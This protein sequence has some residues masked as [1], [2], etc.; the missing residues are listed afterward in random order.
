MPN[1][2]NAF[3]SKYGILILIAIVLSVVFAMFF[4]KPER[5]IPEKCMIEGFECKGIRMSYENSNIRFELHNS[6]SKGLM[7]KSIQLYGED[8]LSCNKLFDNG[9]GPFVSGVHIAPDGSAE[10]QVECEKISSKLVNSGNIVLSARI[11]WYAEDSSEALSNTTNG[12]LIA[13]VGP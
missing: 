11:K 13:H 2:T 9:W 7:V 5:L 1:P 12:E 3:L 10:A 4:F 8:G 6:G